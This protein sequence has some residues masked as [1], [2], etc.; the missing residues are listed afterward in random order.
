MITPEHVEELLA[1]DAERA[2]LV[3]VASAAV[4]VPEAALDTDDYRGALEVV[5][6]RDLRAQLDTDAPSRRDLEEVAARLDSTVTRL[7][8]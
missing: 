1:S 5:T 7:G 6:Q 2:V 3:V 4:V 8:A